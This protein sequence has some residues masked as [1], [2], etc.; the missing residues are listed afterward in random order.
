MIS[1]P[2]PTLVDRRATTEHERACLVERITA[3][4]ELAGA[5]ISTHATDPGTGLVVRVLVT[6]TYTQVT[7]VRQLLPRDVSARG[8]VF[9]GESHASIRWEL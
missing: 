2:A 4:A 8:E 3:A 9:L 1:T 5:L 7:R 6:G